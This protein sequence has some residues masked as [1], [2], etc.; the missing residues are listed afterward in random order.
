MANIKRR[1]NNAA[2]RSLSANMEDCN[3]DEFKRQLTLADDAAIGVIL[4]RT[5]EIMRAASVIE[6]W[7][8]ETNKPF[9]VWDALDGL[10]RYRSALG[11]QS[12]EPGL[13][14][15]TDGELSQPSVISGTKNPEA[16][17]QR[18]YDPTGTDIEK[19]AAVV[20]LTPEFAINSPI[21][22]FHQAL[23]YQIRQS[24]QNE[25]RLFLV[26]AID[27]QIPTAVE[28]ELYVIDFKTPS[29]AELRQN[30]D[31]LLETVT[32]TA[33]VNITSDECDIVVQNGLGMTM[34]DFENAAALAI[35][36]HQNTLEETGEG[37]GVNE[38]TASILRSKVDALK[39]TDML[40][41]LPPVRMDQ[42]GG[43]SEL[44]SWVEARKVAFSQEAKEYGVDM[45]KGILVVGPPGT[46]KSLVS[47]AISSTLNVPC[48]KFDIGRVFGRFVGESEGRMR[49]AL[50]TIEAMAPCVLM[51]DEIDKQFGGVSDGGH[52]TTLRVFGTM[53][54]W[55][56]ER[57]TQR[58]PIFVTMTANNVEGLPPELL[59]KG[60][61]DQI[62]SVSFP[63]ADE[64][65]QILKIHLA[66]RGH[67]DDLSDAELMKVVNKTDRYVGAELEA[68]VSEAITKSFAAGHETVPI[69]ALIDETILINPL[70]SAFADRIK[71]MDDWA[72]KHARPSSGTRSEI[73]KDQRRTRSLA[74][75]A[76]GKRIL[77]PKQ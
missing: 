48:I 33:S 23:R 43:M 8:A 74:P 34:H 41:L 55:M 3:A 61:L 54:T 40:E 59:R 38:F 50:A 32:E 51:I 75:S 72:N 46:G 44:I 56:Q 9:F 1:G 47:K 57:Q 11:T 42:V 77:R 19:T 5:R 64:R 25:Q 71:R 70:S 29:H 30:L 12:S 18:I 53:L 65:L 2:A 21:P 31:S 15:G 6:E 22:H 24:K 4:V 36:Q 20:M 16:C 73:I 28:D 52:D 60:R 45:P 14:L 13:D 62:W 49:K 37:Y 7:A 17:L 66:A 39:K 35:I 10:K 69:S 27:A 68:V 26:C 67:G 58:S 63:E 76:N